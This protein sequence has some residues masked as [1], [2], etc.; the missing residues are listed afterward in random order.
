MTSILPVNLADLLYCRGVESERVE[1]K[2][3]WNPNT[4]GPQVLKTICAFANDYH[5]LNGGYIV[6]GVAEE[7]GRAAM[8][9]AGLTPAEVEDAQKWIRGNCRRLDPAFQPIFSP[10]IIADRNILVIWAPASE[11]RP[12]RAPGGSK[13]QPR[14]WVRLGPETVD[15]EQRGDVLRRLVEQAAKTPWDD[16]RAFDAR[17][18]DLRETRVREFLRDVRSGLLDEP[19][20]AEVLRAMRITVPVNQHEAPRNVGLLFFSNEPDRWYRG[21]KIDV[22]QFAAD[23][24]GDV[25][26]E[27]TFSGPLQDQFRQCLNY[28]ENLSATHLQKQGDRSQTRSWVSY[29]L[30]AL[31]ETL[32]NALYHRSYDTDQPEPTKVYVYPGRIEITSYPGPVPGIKPDHLTR[33]SRPPAVPARNSRIGEYFKELKLAEGRL[34]GLAKV[35]Q[36][37]EDNGSPPP[38]FEFDTAR[39]Y[40]R[41]TLPAHPEYAALSALRDAA[42]LRALG[43]DDQAHRRIISAWKVK[44]VS[45]ALTAELIRSYQKREDLPGAEK[46]WAAFRAEAP[47]HTWPRVA[48]RMIEFWLDAKE[49]DKAMRLLDEQLHLGPKNQ[50]ALDAAKRSGDIIQLG[51][52]T[53]HE[54]AKIKIRLAQAVHYDKRQGWKETNEK[55]LLEAREL[56]EHIVQLD[57]P[58]RRRA[59][60]W[61]DLA[62]VRNRLKAPASAVEEAYAKAA[63]L[64]PEERLLVRELDEFKTGRDGS[65]GSGPGYGT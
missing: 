10:E 53:L 34:T 2:A 64:A 11:V 36:A 35:F 1:F 17:I 48:S 31:Q 23:R 60:A 22:V 58:P 24:G 32:V 9:P 45:A 46:A 16:R 26:E 7:D 62:R 4:T 12:H 28:L 8:P 63:K 56:L 40:F 13:G 37:M 38:S 49:N 65:G 39:T 41:A 27:R 55:L 42:H 44:P 52:R 19:D 54:F 33:D 25:L 3:S 21:A 5:N 6:V 51:P 50:G 30:P 61:R 59:L 20:A 47:A 15:A 43:D 57:A 29:P 18:E 14:F